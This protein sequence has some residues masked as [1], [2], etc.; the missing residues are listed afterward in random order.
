MKQD[1]IELRVHPH[2]VSVTAL[3]AQIVEQAAKEIARCA[4]G[5]KQKDRSRG[6]LKVLQ[7]L[8]EQCGFPHSRSG[9]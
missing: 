3:D 9:D 4:L 7:E 1:V 5:L 6:S 8:K 2:R